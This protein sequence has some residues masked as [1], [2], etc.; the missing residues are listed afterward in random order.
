MIIA[1]L[2]GILATIAV[3][4]FQYKQTSSASSLYLQFDAT[5]EDDI[6]SVLAQRK[7]TMMTGI[8]APRIWT[9]KSIAESDTAGGASLAI[10]DQHKNGAMFRI[11][12]RNYLRSLRAGGASNTTIYNSSEI[13]TSLGIEQ[14]IDEKTK[15][16]RGLW[17]YNIV[18]DLYIVG[19]E[20]PFYPLQRVSAEWAV[21]IPTD[22]SVCV[23]FCHSENSRFLQ[24]MNLNKIML[25]DPNAANEFPLLSE[26]HHE[27]AIVRPGYMMFIPAH[28]Y[29]T[30]SAYE[31]PHP[32]TDEDEEPTISLGI[33]G[34]LHSPIS[35]LATA[36]IRT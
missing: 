36:T 22:G 23:T 26:V 32:P 33:I 27:G 11:T 10:Q 7:V 16:Y 6:P 19:I 5:T 31:E 29:F 34:F 2:I 21:I 3:F 24:A 1:I 9:M 4:I 18:P 13:A 15:D 17:L 30:V 14:I 28:W 25:W 35:K 20:V 8:T 12:A